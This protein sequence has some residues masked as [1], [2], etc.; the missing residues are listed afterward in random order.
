MKQILNR[1][2]STG[3]MHFP[4]PRSPS[5]QCSFHLSYFQT[6]VRNLVYRKRILYVTTVC[7]VLF[8]RLDSEDRMLGQF[9]TQYV[10]IK[11][12]KMLSS[13][14]TVSFGTKNEGCSLI[15]AAGLITFTVSAL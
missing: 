9:N 14:F 2:L 5:E 3:I 12:L 13:R 1:I 11:T 8:Y 15:S 10:I 4:N 7:I 6:Q